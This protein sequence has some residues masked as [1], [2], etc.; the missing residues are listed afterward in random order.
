MTAPRSR[1]ARRR[2]TPLSSTRTRRSGRSSS[3]RAASSRNEG[4][5]APRHFGADLAARLATTERMPPQLIRSWLC[6]ARACSRACRRSSR[7]DAPRCRRSVADAMAQASPQ[8]MAEYRRKLKEYEEARAAVRA[9]P[10][11]NSISEKRR[12]R[13]AK[14]RA[15][16][17][18]T[19]DDY[20][21]T[22]PPVY[23]GPKKPVDPSA[24]EPAARA[25]RSRWSPDLIQAAAEAIPVH[26]AAPGER[27][28]VQARLCQ[29]RAAAGLTRE[30][31]VRVY[32]F[33]TGGNGNYDMQSGI[34]HAARGRS[35]PRSATTSCSP[36]TASS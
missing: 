10:Y 11:W 9:R 5:T 30:Q 29:G 27:S 34:E 7:M 18:I 15:G 12:G 28:R 13:N 23:S 33:E 19:L 25:R 4:G 26:A 14:R 16:Q 36:P 24:P 1:R 31:A 2:N 17:Q 6:R 8:A 35:R 3:R 21:L 22:Q 20:V 32:S